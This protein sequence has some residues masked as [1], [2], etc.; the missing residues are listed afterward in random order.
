MGLQSG[1]RGVAAAA[2]GRSAAA[3]EKSN[4]RLGQT[5]DINANSEIIDEGK[6]SCHECKRLVKDNDKGVQCDICE[7]WYHANCVKI[8]S[9]VYSVISVKEDLDWYCVT[10]KR[11]IK[12]N[13]KDLN[14]LHLEN[15]RLKEENK[16]LKDRMIDLEDQMKNFKQEIKGELMTEVAKYMK[17]MMHEVKE[18]EEKNDKVNNLVFFNVKESLKENGKEREKKLTIIRYI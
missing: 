12:Q 2:G 10:C 6:S 15:E 1:P 16:S 9:D 7:H 11:G 8:S 14:T 4:N 13:K 18:R 17:E 5:Y 3:R